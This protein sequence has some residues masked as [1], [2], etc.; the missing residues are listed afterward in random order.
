MCGGG[1]IM[2][3]GFWWGVRSCRWGVTVFCFRVLKGFVM[4]SKYD[5]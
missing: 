1:R 4:Y 5:I 3:V 2:G